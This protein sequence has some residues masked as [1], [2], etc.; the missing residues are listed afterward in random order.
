MNCKSIIFSYFKKHGYR[1]LIGVVCVIIASIFSTAIPKLLGDAID[2]LEE[3]G[4][5]SEIPGIRKVA[6]AIALCAFAAFVM[7]FIWRY[8]IFGFTR[9]IELHLRHSIFSRL[10]ELSQDYYVKNNTGDLITRGIVDVQAVRMLFGGGL[11]GFIEIIS[12]AV[13]T[14][15]Y[16]VATANLG[17]TA[18]S[19][20]PVPILL[21]ILVKIRKV[22]RRKYAEVQASVSDIAS[23]VQENI[24]GIRVIKAFSQESD[25]NK[26]F[27]E[28]SK[29]KWK[30]E[31]GFTKAW[32]FVNPTSSFVFGVVFSLF[33]YF[34]GKAVINGSLSLGE[35]VAFNTYIVYLLDPVSRISHLVQVWQR[36]LV[37]IQRMDVIL[38]ST[39]TVDD[40]RAKPEITELGNVG[41]SVKGLTYS[42]PGTDTEVLKDISFDLRPGEVLAV[43]GPTGCGKST[44]MSL[45]MRMWEAPD[46]SIT[47]NG[48]AIDE[49][50]LRTLRSS[51]SYVPQEAFLFSDTIMNNIIFYDDAITPDD[52]VAAA[53]VAA[54]HESISEFQ[55]GYNTIV[56]E[57]GMTL[58]GGQ[59][60]RISIARAIS[61]KP[62]LL[63][64]DDCLSAVDAETEH[65]IIAGLREYIQGCTTIIV[66]H[67]IAAASL[68]DRILLL[69][70]DGRAEALGTHAELS[71]TSEAY[72]S[73]IA[74]SKA[75][76]EKEGNN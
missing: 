62:G 57:R 21:F 12:N 66:T 71:Q 17:L 31:I 63:L 26:R 75:N 1:Y 67:R 50:P 40:S 59:K 61:R 20:I 35:F 65:E 24:T 68:A 56:G 27:E 47:V 19:V 33:L 18:I 44:I 15:S 3:A 28:L 46:D 13:I 23:K 32:A 39:P 16:M 8:F 37:S 72:R 70:E 9:S 53:K 25:E 60:Q 4:S 52:A 29:K 42:Y 43:M 2:M 58:S 22:M 14:I 76:S 49:I 54:V 38:S 45:L 41:I 11:V 5:L 48:H 7:K 64:L 36:G 30:A 51:I 10:Q 34:G 73:L 69:S 6:L 55:E 74:L